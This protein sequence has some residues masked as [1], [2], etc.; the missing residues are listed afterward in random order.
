MREFYT[1]SIIRRRPSSSSTRS[2]GRRSRAGADGGAHRARG[3]RRARVPRGGCPRRVRGRALPGCPGDLV[4]L[5]QR[6]SPGP[7][8]RHRRRSRRWFS[9]CAARASSRRSRRRG[10]GGCGRGLSESVPQSAG[11]A[12]YP[13]RFVGRG[14]RRSARHLL[15]AR[16]HGDPVARVRVRARRGRGRVRDR[17]GCAGTI[18]SWC[19]CWPAS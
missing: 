1:A 6:S 14:V 11:L 2:S 8:T 19:W 7:R 4:T 15:V 13:W 5:V 17:R 3:R 10:A 16:C 9:A 18:R 12:R